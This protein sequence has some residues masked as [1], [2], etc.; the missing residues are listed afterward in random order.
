MNNWTPSAENIFHEIS[1]RIL[2]ALVARCRRGIPFKMAQVSGH[3]SIYQSS[4]CIY[5]VLKLVGMAH[6]SV[7]RNSKVFTVSCWHYLSLALFTTYWI[8]QCVLRY[9]TEHR[10]DSGLNYQIV[11]SIWKYVF[12]FQFFCT[13][14]IIFFNFVKRKHVEDFLRLIEKFDVD[15]EQ[16]GWKN[17]VEIGRFYK[18]LPLVPMPIIIINH[19]IMVYFEFT[20]NIVF[21]PSYIYHIKFVAYLGMMEMF[22]LI[23]YIFIASCFCIYRRIDCLCQIM[24][25]VCRFVKKIDENSIIFRFYFPLDTSI[26]AVKMPPTKERYVIRNIL[27]LYDTLLDAVDEINANFSI[28]VKI[29]FSMPKFQ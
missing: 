25:W 18:F 14:P 23:C 7:E 24:R 19:V 16:L 27:A 20:E 9:K 28:Q 5:Y 15:V 8:A 22:F 6:Y 1:A 13:I 10:H 2:M 21:N 11:E 17:E 26:I 12:A 3:K 4:V 29:R